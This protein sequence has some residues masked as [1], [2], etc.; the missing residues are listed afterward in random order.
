VITRY[1]AWLGGFQAKTLKS[2]DS[3]SP[4][5]RM[6]CDTDC[7]ETPSYHPPN[8]S[9]QSV[10]G[11]VR[12][13]HACFEPSHQDLHDDNIKIMLNLVRIFSKM[14]G[15]ISMISVLQRIG[16]LPWLHTHRAASS[17]CGWPSLLLTVRGLRDASCV[18]RSILNAVASKLQSNAFSVHTKTRGGGRSA[19]LHCRTSFDNLLCGLIRI[20]LEVLGE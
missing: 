14:F 6:R 9:L 17:M 1:S 13:C 12:A 8:G 18:S 2:G 20:L 19:T 15:V 7:A 16:I 10:C 11:I 5:H 3:T 4:Q